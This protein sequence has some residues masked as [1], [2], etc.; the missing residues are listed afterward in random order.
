MDPIRLR[1]FI[2][3]AGGWIYAVST[4]DNTEKV[5]CVLRYVPDPSG[6][7]VNATGERYRKFDFE[8]AFAFIADHKPQY[9]GSVLRI[10]LSDVERVLKPD[11]EMPRI[12][13][14]HP[15]VARL[16]KIL[17][18]PPGFIGC[19]GSLLCGLEN[20]DSDIDLVVYGKHWFAARQTLQSAIRAGNLDGL[21]PEMW[22]RVYEKRK[23]EIPFDTFVLH[24]ERKWNRGQIEGT[25]FDLLFTRSYEDQNRI[26][27]GHGV[28]LGNATIEARVTD[29]SFAFDSPA[30]YEVEHSGFSRV[31]SFTHTYS[32]QAFPGETIEA[33]GV[34]E[35]HGNER[36]L[37]VGTTRE[38]KGEYI[39][40]KTLLDQRLHK[41]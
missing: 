5:G 26:T 19:T 7:R 13:S 28:N 18:V 24:E 38:A 11:R 36:W 8:D 4:Y 17:D 39:V 29:A 25:Y 21:S 30:V 23:P 33:C 12:A 10:P 32:G 37:V 6:E 1:D 16:A 27:Y 9:L 34:A 15:R 41:V 20:K 14:G 2:V 3:D 22:R 40:S 35:Q 31:L